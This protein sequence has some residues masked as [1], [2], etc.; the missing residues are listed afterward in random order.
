VRPRADQAGFVSGSAVLSRWAHSAIAGAAVQGVRFG[1]VVAQPS[2][3]LIPTSH[4][5]NDRRPAIWPWLL[6]PLVVLILFV[7]L[8]NVRQLPPNRPAGA[9]AH[10]TSSAT[11]DTSDP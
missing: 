1:A 11:G 4:D 7:I 8:Y 6:M 2:N 5:A 3:T 10:T 9:D